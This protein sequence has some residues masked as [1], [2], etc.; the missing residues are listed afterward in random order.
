MIHLTMTPQTSAIR[1]YDQPGGYENRL[2]YLAIV[3]V[4]HLTDK[5]VYLHGAVGKVDR[6][7]WEKTLDL[8]RAHGATTVM[9]ERHGVM[10]TIQL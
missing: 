7:T 2:P 4:T 3:T 6:E 9:L 8:L 5:V 10:K 1:A